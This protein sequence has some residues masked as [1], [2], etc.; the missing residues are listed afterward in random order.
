VVIEAATNTGTTTYSIT[1]TAANLVGTTS[2]VRNSATDIVVTGTANVAEAVTINNAT[3]SGLTHYHVSDAVVTLQASLGTAEQVVAL[4]NA[5]SVTAVSAVTASQIDMSGFAGSNT[6]N[7]IITA[8]GLDNSID[9]G[10]GN[11]IINAQ[12]GNDVV[13]GGLGQD[14]IN[15]GAGNDVVIIS[16]TLARNG[17]DTVNDFSATDKLMF[18]FGDTS[19]LVQTD[20]RGTGANYEEIA[21][22]GVLGADTG[23]VVLTD[24][25]AALDVATAKAVANALQGVGASD[26]FFLVFDNGTSTA[27]FRI[28]ET[29]AGSAGLE[30]QLLITLVG[31]ADASAVLSATQFP[32][33]APV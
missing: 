17:S 6:V 1:D 14:T 16:T 20:L 3:N 2:I 31:V 5:L 24:S 25:Q 19:E 23:L 32:D 11:D 10:D 7:L 21:S 8:N 9:G 27:L 29:D 22:G 26:Q 15:T 18:N 28:A 4:Q 13:Y 33:F 30:A 12:G